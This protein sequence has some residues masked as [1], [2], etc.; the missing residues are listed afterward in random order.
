M[1]APLRSR[2]TGHGTGIA[3]VAVSGTAF[4]ALAIFA[5]LAYAAGADPLTVLAVRFVIAGV[6]MVALLRLRGERLPRGRTL[7]GL[8]AMGGIG[9]VTQSLSFFFALTVASAALVSL[10]LYVFPA[11]VAVLAAVVLKQRLSPLKI[12]AVVLALVGTALTI[13]QLGG[14]T[15]LGIALGLLSAVAYAIYILIS[16]QLTPRAGAIPATTVVVLSAAAV[17]STIALVRGPVFPTTAGGWAAI[18]GLAIVSTVIAIGTFFAGL[19]RIGPAEASTISTLEPLVT[20]VL[21]AA[22]LGEKVAPSQLL[23]GILILGAV[24]VLARAGRPVLVPQD[25]PPA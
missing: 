12:G 9:Y 20:V 17:L 4:G 16:S 11:I 21:A 18:A 3:L 19:E 7:G 25:A 13:G 2:A 23:G 14:G 15:P 6:C 5:K 10:L 8:A 1:A 24:I 22:V